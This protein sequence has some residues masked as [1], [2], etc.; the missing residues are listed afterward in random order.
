MTE[1]SLQ[2]GGGC[3][4][5]VACMELTNQYRGLNWS[6][7]VAFGDEDANSRYDCSV[8]RR[9]AVYAQRPLVCVFLVYMYDAKYV[10]ATSSLDV[11]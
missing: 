10:N 2:W 7:T 1:D 6:L 11:H 4:N 5:A 8:Q 9:G 3:W